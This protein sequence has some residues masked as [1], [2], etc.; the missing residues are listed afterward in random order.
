MRRVAEDK[1]AN[2]LAKVLAFKSGRNFVD[3]KFRTD[4][5]RIRSLHNYLIH[6]DKQ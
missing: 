4:K 6:S 2:L 3:T 5:V 1:Q